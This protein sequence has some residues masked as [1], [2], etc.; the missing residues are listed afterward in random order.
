MQYKGVYKNIRD[1]GR[2]LDV[3]TVLEGSVRRAG[4]Q[5]RVAAQLI[6]VADGGHLWAEVYDKEMTEIFAIQSDIARQ[7]AVA[8]EARLLSPEEEQIGKKPTGNITAYDYYLKGREYYYRHNHQGYEM[9]GNFFVKALE[10]DSTYALA[11]AGLADAC[12]QRDLLDSA[13]TLSRRAIAMDPSLPEAYKALGLA[14]YYKGWMQKSLE[15]SLHAIKLNSNHFPATVNVGWA[16]LETDPVEALPWLKKAF[17]LAPTSASV[18]GAIGTAYMDLV[19]EANAEKWFNKSLELAPDYL[20]SHQRL[21]HL[22]MQGGQYRAAE[23]IRQKIPSNARYF[24]ELLALSAL[25]ERNYAQA[26]KD[27]EKTI[28]IDSAFQSLEL[29]YVYDKTGKERDARR[30]FDR[31]FNRSRRRIEEGNER[32]LPRYDLARINAALHRK[33]EAYEWLQK[34]IDA[35]WI[36]YRWGMIDPL[37]ESLHNDERFV[38]MMAQVKAKVDQMRQRVEMMEQS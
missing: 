15:A 27:F 9:A 22:Y 23:A 21:W 5:V 3:A 35:G 2:K 38:Q 18:A 20:R 14:Y 17:M 24:F 6:D 12:A 13:I 7:I 31:F 36:E 37:L 25:L 4:N 28:S 33:L 11:Y 16:L 8:L 10:L 32:S 29:A 26:M 1:I 34:A 30:M 19:D